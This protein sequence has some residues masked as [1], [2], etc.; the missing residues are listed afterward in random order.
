MGNI[1]AAVHG[2][3]IIRISR[4]ILLSSL[5]KIAWQSLG[6]FVALSIRRFCSLEEQV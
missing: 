4:G 1:F 6:V 3:Y 2:I 5:G